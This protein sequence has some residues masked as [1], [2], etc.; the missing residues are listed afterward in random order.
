MENL[1]NEILKVDRE[2]KQKL[3][4][5]EEYRRE[6]L[7]ALQSKK[8]EIE[9]EEIRNAI[10][11]LLQKGEERKSAGDK[12]LADLAES[13]KT[14]EEKMKKL[15]EQNGDQWVKKIVDGVING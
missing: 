1:L 8:E 10:D 5:A 15:Y 7:V 6:Q 12:Q 11:A 13:H 2:A 4:E 3:T 14:A 9:K